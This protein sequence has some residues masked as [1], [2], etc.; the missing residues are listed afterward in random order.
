MRLVEPQ[1]FDLLE[2]LICNR[3]RVVSRDD[4]FA[5]IWRGRVVSESVLSTRINAVRSLVGDTGSVQ[6]LVRTYRRKG[7]RFV[8]AVR[9]ERRPAAVSE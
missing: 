7:L 9:E 1:V 8:G 3:D 6:R 4:I 5:A 2:F